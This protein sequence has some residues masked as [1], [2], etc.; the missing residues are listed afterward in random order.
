MSA[1]VTD[2]RIKGIEALLALALARSAGSG[3]GGG[4]RNDFLWVP[5]GTPGEGVVTTFAAL[6]PLLKAAPGEKRVAIDSSG[7]TPHI[8]AGAWDGITDVTFVAGG[9]T[10]IQVAVIIDDGATF[11]GTNRLT[12]D[13]VTPEFEGTT[14]PFLSV[15]SGVLVVNLLRGSAVV[16]TGGQPFVGLTG[17]ATLLS[18]VSQAS[19]WAAATINH[20]AAGVTSNLLFFDGSEMEAGAVTGG[21]GTLNLSIDGSSAA[22]VSIDQSPA[23]T[24]SYVDVGDTLMVRIPIALVSTSSN[25]S[26]PFGAIVESAKLDITTPYSA[27]ATIELG[28][29]GALSEF[30]GTGDNNPQAAAI[31][32]LDQDTAAASTNPL[33]VTI[34]GAPAAGAGFAIVKFVIETFS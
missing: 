5:N 25:F 21:V 2:D 3:G 31:Y 6:A 9:A 19:E 13:G 22:L 15:S 11:T 18:F 30:M 29:T 23:P 1:Q 27:G 8:T 32:V 17:T 16:E 10:P 28:Q 33:L 26:L 4:G 24:L 20:G 14:V 34:G 12:F 7:G